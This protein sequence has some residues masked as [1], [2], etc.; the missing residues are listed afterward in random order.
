MNK[1]NT[2]NKALYFNPSLACLPPKI[3]EMDI[4]S[5][6]PHRSETYTKVMEKIDTLLLKILGN[7]DFSSILLAGNGTLANEIMIANLIISANRPAVLIN[8]EF[9]ERLYQQCLKYNPQT[10]AIDF[11]FG[12]RIEPAILHIKL[13]DVDTLFF[14]ALETSVGILN[15]VKEICEVCEAEGIQVSIDAISAM[16]SEEIDFSSPC[17]SFIS[18]SSG[19]NLASLPGISIVFIR[20]T[21]KPSKNSSLP[22]C[23]DMDYLLKSKDTQGLVRNTL[24]YFLVKALYISLNELINT[25]GLVYQYERY[26][27]F[28]QMIISA[29]SMMNI[30][31]LENSNAS[32]ILSFYC[33]NSFVWDSIIKVLKEQNIT[34]YYEARYLKKNNI[35]QIAYMGFYVQEDIERMLYVFSQATKSK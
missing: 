12:K 20:N 22:S 30:S 1:Q 24:S 19:K 15:P 28:R 14:V 17:I 13:K 18:T 3:R 16:G 5:L 27:Y 6:V 29:M 35:F 21:I 34:V 31:I 7:E 10:L 26:R 2:I 4:M 8:G 23:I 9:G 25:V 33:P 32:N 11:G